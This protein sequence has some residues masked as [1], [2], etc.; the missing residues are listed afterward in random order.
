MS[1]FDAR[2]L[3][4]PR[5]LP[6]HDV[7]GLLCRLT[8]NRRLAARDLHAKLV[9]GDVHAMRRCLHPALADR[10]LVPKS[11]WGDNELDSWSDRTFVRGPF[12]DRRG[13]RYFIFYAWRSDLERVWPTVFPPAPAPAEQKIVAPRPGSAAAWILDLHPN[14]WRLQ[15]AG[16]IF[17]EATARG[18][19]RTKRSFERALEKLKL[20]PD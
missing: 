13:N 9:T 2:P 6:I 16:R 10:E 4:D 15:S 20:L 3:D 8:D 11:F 14:D 7:I 12:E 17:Q 18:C 1:D 5:W 19:T